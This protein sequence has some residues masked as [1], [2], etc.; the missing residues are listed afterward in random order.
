MEGFGFPQRDI[1]R[2]YFPYASYVPTSQKEKKSCYK[3]HEI[4]ETNRLNRLIYYLAVPC[5][6]WLPGYLVKG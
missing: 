1:T 4:N 2:I 3:P 6:K 5:S